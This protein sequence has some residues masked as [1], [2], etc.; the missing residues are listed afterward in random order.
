M[1][2][3]HCRSLVDFKGR[4]VITFLADGTH[5]MGEDGDRTLDPSGRDGMERGS[6]TW[7][8]PPK[9]SRSPPRSTRPVNGDCPTPPSSPSPPPNS[10]SSPGMGH[11]SSSVS[12]RI[13]IRSSA[14]GLSA[15]AV[16]TRSPPSLPMALTSWCRTAAPP[17][18]E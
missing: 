15:R 12:V 3:L 9:E 8:P 11:S 6:Y 1:L 17:E 10:S 16:A 2:A 4:A 18:A 13:A 5:T 7:T 14:H